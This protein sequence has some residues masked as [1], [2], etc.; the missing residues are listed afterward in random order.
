MTIILNI[1]DFDFETIN[2]A[3]VQGNLKELASLI[4]SLGLRPI[5]QVNVSKTANYENFFRIL[6]GLGFEGISLETV[7]IENISNS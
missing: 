2:S 5:I 1:T 3:S 4:R 7:E 6:M